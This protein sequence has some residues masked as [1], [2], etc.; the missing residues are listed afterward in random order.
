MIIREATDA[1]RSFIL[2]LSPTLTE[3]AKLFWHSDEVVV[4][5][6][7]RYAAEA[8]DNTQERQM[9]L[10]AETDG[11]PA[12]FIIV[13]ES[14]DEISLEVCAKVPLL[15]VAK[16]FHGTGIAKKLMDEAEKWAK[17]HGHR[18]LQLEVFYNNERARAFYEKQGFHNDTI[19]MVK[20]LED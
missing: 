2:S 1:D 6:Q 19:V 10:I 8:L 4:Q 17:A 5:F 14:T 9:T 15:A 11:V 12:G 13:S 20:P 18:L 16:E 3:G 7:D